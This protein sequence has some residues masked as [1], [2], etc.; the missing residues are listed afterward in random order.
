VVCDG[1]GGGVLQEDGQ[2]CATELCKIQSSLFLSVKYR[3][4]Y[5]CLKYIQS[6]VH[7]PCTELYISDPCISE[8]CIAAR[9]EELRISEKKYRAL[10]FRSFLSSVFQKGLRALL[11]DRALLQK[12]PTELCISAKELYMSAK[13]PYMSAKDIGGQSS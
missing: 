6:S 11:C 1:R 12:Y 8:L 13:E 7:P 5:F 9:Y 2:I 4:L 10:Y 3:A